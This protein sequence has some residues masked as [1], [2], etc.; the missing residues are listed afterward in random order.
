LIEERSI[1]ERSI[2]AP[3][4]REKPG[5]AVLVRG[6]NWVHGIPGFGVNGFAALSGDYR[7][8]GPSSGFTVYVTRELLYFSEDW[9]LRPGM[10]NIELFQRSGEEEDFTALIL[11]DSQGS[12]WTVVFLFPPGLAG[13]GLD[14][15]AFNRL[16]RAWTARLS[17]FLFFSASPQDISLPG[18][19]EF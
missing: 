19:V 10:G 8:E 13:T 11:D 18:A 1:E 16:L 7:F 4:T 2:G 14:A 12:F 17:Y 9:R 3:V 6:N 5:E 15:E